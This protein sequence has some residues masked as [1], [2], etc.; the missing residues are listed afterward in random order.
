MHEIEISLEDKNYPS[1]NYFNYFSI[2]NVDYDKITY[3]FFF[4]NYML[5][6]VPCIIKNVSLNWECNS[7]WIKNGTISYDYFIQEYGDLEAPIADCNKI[8]FN[9]HTKTDMKVATYMEYLKSISKEKLLYLKDWHL[10]KLRRNDYFYEVPFT[11]AS[12]WLNEFAV[13]HNQD[14]FMFV[15]IGPQESWTPL[16]ADVYNS[17]SWSVNVVGRKKWI[18]FPPGE[19]ENLKDSLGNLP[20]LVHT[21]KEK[22]AKYLEIIQEPGD[23]IFV[24]SGWFHQVFNLLDTISINHNWINACNIELVWKALQKCLI[25]V[26]KEIEEFKGEPEYYS[27]C[28]LILKSVF[29]MDIGS[30][31]TFLSYISKK[32]VK[33]LENINLR[34]NDHKLG[35]NHIRFDIKVLSTIINSIDINENLFLNNDLYTNL[36][37]D[38]I[39]TKLLL[40]TYN[41]P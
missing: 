8:N 26:E 18:L 31:M 10:R 24:P 35:E 11:F 9:A 5:K 22:T 15:Y 28:E 16:H 38:F 40:S 13:D 32:R 21:D 3:D 2:D 1:Y 7:K 37:T 30:F 23:A 25:S 19:E 34:F 36:K 20:L 39:E 4:T 6:N 14:D 17:F 12:D 27:Q 33:Q 29:G 41:K